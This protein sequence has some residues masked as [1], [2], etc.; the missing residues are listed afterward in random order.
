M[1]CALVSFATLVQTLISVS[2]RAVGLRMR[3]FRALR[4]HLLTPGLHLTRVSIFGHSP[5]GER[6]WASGFTVNSCRLWMAWWLEGEKIRVLELYLLTPWLLKNK[7][8]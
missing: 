3:G 2:P 1:V 8:K 4:L 7:N 6:L 5:S